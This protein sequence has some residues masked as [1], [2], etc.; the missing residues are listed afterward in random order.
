MLKKN[1]DGVDVPDVISTLEGLG[2]K[3]FKPQ[4]LGH[5]TMEALLEDMPEY[6]LEFVKGDGDTPSRVMPAGSINV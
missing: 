6:V 2:V 4:L 3:N 1:P 5:E